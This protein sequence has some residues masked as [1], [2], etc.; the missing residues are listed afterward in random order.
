MLISN[1]SSGSGLVL[2]WT[3]DPTVVFGCGALLAI[4][5]GAV[6][7]KLNLK[8]VLWGF[9]VLTIFI[10]LTSPMHDLGERYLFS[11][12]MLQHLLL[13]LVAAPL[14]VMGLPVGLLKRALKIKWVAQVEKVLSQPLFAWFFSIGTL[15]VWHIP[16]LYNA[17]LTNHDIHIVEHLTFLIS[18]VIFWWTGLKPIYRLQ[19]NTIPAMLYFFFAALG[20]SILGLF[21][22]FAPTSLFPTYENPIDTDN[23]LPL[24]RGEWNLTAA[25][26]QQIGGVMMWATG[27]FGYITGIIV[28]M[29]RWY[30]RDQL[31]TYRE[32][33]ALELASETKD[34][35]NEKSR[36]AGASSKA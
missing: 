2:H 4:Y 18:A 29:V 13:L 1:I 23:M 7:F 25:A 20:S 27:G 9:G 33:M 26:D 24:L 5:A 10:S 12:H 15:W 31:K 36:L 11:A 19:M 28:V 8:G 17:A 14:L 21:L 6:G 3:F 22:S 32:N 30:K 16:D 35:E 34:A